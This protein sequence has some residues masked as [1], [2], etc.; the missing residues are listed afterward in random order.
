ML[1]QSRT[2]CQCFLRIMSCLAQLRLGLP[3]RGKLAMG[4]CAPS[5]A[6]LAASLSPGVDA[7]WEHLMCRA[8]R[9]VPPQVAVQ[10]AGGQAGGQ[11]RLWRCGDQSMMQPTNLLLLH[12]P[13]RSPGPAAAL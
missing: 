9:A 3:R 12:S 10:T 2:S 8:E 1:L 5:A 13:L 6:L 11:A 4:E 7:P